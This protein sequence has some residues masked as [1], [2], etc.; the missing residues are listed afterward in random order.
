MDRSGGIGGHRL[1]KI[2][3]CLSSADIQLHE[4]ADVAGEGDA[5]STGFGLRG[6]EHGVGDGRVDLGGILFELAVRGL[7]SGQLIVGE[8][9]LGPG[10]GEMVGCAGA[11]PPQGIEV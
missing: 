1:A 10:C 7:Q 9:W 4:R 8:V 5:A 3:V 6:F 11:H 2:A